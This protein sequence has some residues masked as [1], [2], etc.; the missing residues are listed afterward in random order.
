MNP[1]VLPCNYM[2]EYKFWAEIKTNNKIFFHAL[3]A[4][5]SQESSEQCLTTL[6]QIP[7]QSF[8]LPLTQAVVLII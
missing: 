8:P 3:S 1:Q 5:Q 7:R 4:D 2:L 6:C